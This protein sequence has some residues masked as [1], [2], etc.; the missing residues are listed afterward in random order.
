MK[1]VRDVLCKFYIN[2][3]D[4]EHDMNRTFHE[5]PI[6]G[7]ISPNEAIIPVEVDEYT[8]EFVRILVD[9]D[10]PSKGNKVSQG[11]F[12]L[13]TLKRNTIFGEFIDYAYIFNHVVTDD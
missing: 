13:K 3:E 6:E 11:V 4:A 10:K 1:E 2:L 5:V 7:T 9:E 12:K 8:D